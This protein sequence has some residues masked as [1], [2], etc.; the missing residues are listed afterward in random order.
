MTG[1]QTCALP[2][3]DLVLGSWYDVNELFYI[4]QLAIYLAQVY[5]LDTSTLNQIQICDNTNLFMQFFG[6]ITNMVIKLF[7]RILI[8]F[9]ND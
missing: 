6:G 4:S 8:S 2:I 9:H 3:Y 7:A 1:V 5:F